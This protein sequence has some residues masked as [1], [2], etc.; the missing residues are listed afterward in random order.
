MF[1]SP[2]TVS[3]LTNTIKDTIEYNPE[4]TDVVVK[5]EISNFKSHGSG[6]FYF[7]LKDKDSVIKSVMFKNANRKLNF[8]PRDGQQVIITGYVGVYPQGGSYQLYVSSLHPLGEGDL[9]QAFNEL[10]DKLSNEGLFDPIHKK[11]IPKFPRKVAVITGD[12]SA[13]LKDILITLENRNPSVE[14]VVCCSLVQGV[15]AKR[16]IVEKIQIL[17]KRKDI[18]SIILAR[19]GGSLEDLWP[20]NEE[21]VA[22]AIFNCPI[23]IITGI[24]HETD[25]T[26]ADFVADARAATPTAAAQEVV[27]DLKEL[28]NNLEIY[29][30]TLKN[31][32]LNNLRQKQERLELLSSRP[33]LKRPLSMLN[34]FYQNTDIIYRELV[35]EYRNHLF[36]NKEQITALENQLLG[37]SPNEVLKRG[38]ALAKIQNQILKRT[39]QA[40]VGDSVELILY[41][42]KLICEITEKVGVK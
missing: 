35:K 37:L 17:Q 6:H 20:F 19:G 10:K 30:V 34:T 29:R 13:A 11:E 42:G 26:I 7:T 1:K 22:R 15:F 21:D 9:T 3:D 2:I 25:F 4:L 24:G 39:K 38:Y 5:G 27:Q 18:D 8:T 28:E 36:N 31:A 33:I 14:V 41:D 40:N 23:P 12:R 32:L 16:D